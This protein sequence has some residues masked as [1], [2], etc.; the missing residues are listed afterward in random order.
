MALAALFACHRHLPSICSH[1]C[2]IIP[3][4]AVSLAL[5]RS[6]TF[7]YVTGHGRNWDRIVPPSLLRQSVEMAAA[8]GNDIILPGASPASADPRESPE[9]PAWMA[10]LLR[11]PGRPPL[12]ALVAQDDSLHPWGESQRDRLRVAGT[13]LTNFVEA[14]QECACGRESEIKLGP[15]ELALPGQRCVCRSPASL[16][17]YQR[18]G[19]VAATNSSVLITGET[20]SG[21]EILARFIHAAS[22]RPG[23]L[24]VINCATVPEELVESEL[25]GH[26]RGAFTGATRDYPG[27]FPLAARAALFLD[28]VG[29]LSPRAQAKLLRAVETREIRSLGGHQTRRVDVRIIAATNR[30]ISPGGEPFRADLY[31][32]LA[33]WEIRVPPLRERQEDLDAFVDLFL[34]EFA[35]EI[36]HPVAGLS[37]DARRTLRNYAW[38]GNIRELKKVLRAAIVATPSGHLIPAGVMLSELRALPENPALRDPPAHVGSRSF[39][40]FPAGESRERHLPGQVIDPEQ[41][42]QLYEFHAGNISRIARDLGVLRQTAQKKLR[43]LG[44]R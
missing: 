11:S 16:A 4:A 34:A 39:A 18:A 9:N 21:K 41:L 42:R 35:S 43:R 33:E 26:V 14:G 15:P 20:G 8:S 7:V 23:P 29:D 40:S 37:E 31:Y 30:D 1:L 17:A 3:V 36:P 5:L 13:L 2:G 6:R 28:E 44:L 12:G 38:P 32:R 10:C 27:L 22:H 25:F 19:Q 24:E